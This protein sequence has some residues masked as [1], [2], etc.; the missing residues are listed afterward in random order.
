MFLIINNEYCI[1]CIFKI[2]KKVGFIKIFM[3][4]KLQNFILNCWS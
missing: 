2:S 3:L 1:Y 4:K